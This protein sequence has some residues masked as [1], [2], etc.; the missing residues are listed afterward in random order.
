MENVYTC[1]VVKFIT[2]FHMLIQ[3]ILTTFLVV[4]QNLCFMYEKTNI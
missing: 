4:G 3:S 2:Y 1:T